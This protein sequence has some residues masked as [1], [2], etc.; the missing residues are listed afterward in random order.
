[1]TLDDCSASGRPDPEVSWF[2]QGEVPVE[3]PEAGGPIIAEVTAED[4]GEYVCR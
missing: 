4:Q 1:M 3:L 2:F